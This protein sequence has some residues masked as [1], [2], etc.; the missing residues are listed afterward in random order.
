MPPENKWCNRCGNHFPKDKFSLG[1]GICDKHHTK[2]KKSNVIT[3]STGNFNFL[4]MEDTPAEKNE[5]ILP[6]ERVIPSDKIPPPKP[7]R[8]KNMEPTPKPKI[9]KKNN[10]SPSEDILDFSFLGVHP[11]EKNENILPVEGVITSD[12]IP[13]PK[14][15]RVKKSNQ[16]PKQEK[17]DKI[18]SPPSE[19]ILDFSFLGVHSVEKNEIKTSPVEVKKIDKRS[20]RLK[21]RR[22]KGIKFG[23]DPQELKD[24]LSKM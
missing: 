17:N 3:P 8:V 18:N 1:Y 11:A 4:L 9:I 20:F 2:P 13:P 15:K 16:L 21:W 7:K 14:P 19:D 24:I 5:N 22:E 10:S 23:E 6:V 12:K